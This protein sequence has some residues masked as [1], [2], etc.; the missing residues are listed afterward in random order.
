MTLGRPQSYSM[1]IHEQTSNLPAIDVGARGAQSWL[2]SFI[3]Q[4]SGK[5]W[6]FRIPL[7]N[8][9][10]IHFAPGGAGD[11]VITADPGAGNTIH[12]MKQFLEQ[13]CVLPDDPTDHLR[14][15]SVRL[16]P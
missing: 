5:P 9:E 8:T 1:G 7:A 3:G 14:L 12:Y 4:N 13:H 10:H 2:F 11:Q 15:I 16:V 6:Q